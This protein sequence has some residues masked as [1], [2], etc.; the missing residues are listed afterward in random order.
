[1]PWNREALE[2]AYRRAR[3]QL[4]VVEVFK[5]V[6]VEVAQ[7]VNHALPRIAVVGLGERAGRRLDGIEEVRDTGM[8]GFQ[9]VHDRADR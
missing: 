8:V 6:D 5:Q 2:A 1:M 9:A 4:L 3:A 7:P